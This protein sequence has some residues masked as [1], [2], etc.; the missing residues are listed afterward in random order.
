MLNINPLDVRKYPRNDIGMARLFHDMFSDE[1]LYCA[2]EGEWYSWSG[3][4]WEHDTSLRR[5][6]CA[7]IMH[8][9]VIM[10]AATDAVISNNENIMKYYDG[11]SKKNNRDRIISDAE[12]ISPI[13]SSKFDKDKY[14][15]NCKNGTY[16]LKTGEFRPHNREDFITR[17]SNVTYD[18]DATC[19]QFQKYLIEVMQE[20]T[21]KIEYLLKI[22]A[23]CLTGDTSRECFFVLYG[24]KTRNGKSTFVGTLKYLLGNYAET[25][26][27]ASI[28]RKN[29]S[30]GGSGAMPD[31]AKLQKSR[32]VV[33]SELE[34][35]MILDISLVKTMTGG[36]ELSARHL[37]K[38]EFNFV[39]QFKILIDT[40]Y[41][42][43]MTDDSIF[44]SD[45]LHVLC[46]DRHFELHERNMHLKEILQSEV[47]GIFNLIVPFISVLEKD[48]LSMPKQSEETI[49]E[50]SLNSNNVK[51]FTIDKLYYKEGA[52]ERASDVYNAY[53]DWCNESSY[54]FMGKKR[55]NK[56]LVDLGYMYTEK[57]RHHND[58]GVDENTIWIK[59][60]TLTEPRVQSRVLPVSSEYKNETLQGYLNS[61]NRNDLPF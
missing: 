19:P 7:K 53:K 1:L 10:A 11:L 36:N 45:R 47:N 5:C 42:P 61:I 59:D 6:E 28:T 30:S 43:N 60:V 58:R 12:S 29:I 41:L 40:N 48:G 26:K 17:I 34:E 56:K 8:E 35:N 18:P 14:L 37:Y 51:Q 38:S 13:V 32:L 22:A 2:D 16:N 25:L 39:P 24:D 57:S 49:Y 50:Y 31:I 44:N 4:N 20:D 46:F 15:F 52:Y 33:V 27:P 54:K 9:K 23:Y 3:S 21:A 55:F